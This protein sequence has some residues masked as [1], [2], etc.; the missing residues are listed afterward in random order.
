MAFFFIIITKLL[1]VICNQ[2][3]KIDTTSLQ[4]SLTTNVSIAT[5][6]GA[7]N[8]EQGRAEVDEDVTGGGDG[9]GPSFP[10]VHGRSAGS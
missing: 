3:Q 2:I 10:T 7:A 9:D 4:C 6:V 1:K 5:V 8:D